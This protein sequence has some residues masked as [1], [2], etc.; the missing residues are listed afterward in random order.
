[1]QTRVAKKFSSDDGL[2]GAFIG[3][4]G[5]NASSVE[6]A[7][8]ETGAYYSTVATDLENMTFI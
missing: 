2:G 8:V 3:G 6:I 5:I 1:M 4:Q 7:W